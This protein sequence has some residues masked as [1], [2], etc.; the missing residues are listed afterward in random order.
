MTAN[1]RNRSACGKANQRLATSG[2]LKGVQTPAM[3]KVA[4]VS[5]QTDR[6]TSR[7]KV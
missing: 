1:P 4:I 7:A 2:T 5:N 3:I 6:L